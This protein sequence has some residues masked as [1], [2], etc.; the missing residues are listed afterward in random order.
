VTRTFPS[1]PTF[2][3]ERRDIPVSEVFLFFEE[4]LHGRSTGCIVAMQ[5]GRRGTMVERVDL[6]VRA[7]WLYP[8]DGKTE[9]VRDGEVA[10]RDGR[11]VHAGP[12]RREHWE[13]SDLVDAPG[14]A[15]L[16]G[17]VNCHCH[18]ASTFFRAQTED[19][20]GGRALYTVAFRGEGVVDPMDWARLAVLGT[21]EMAR[22]GI[23]TLNDFWYAPD[24]MGEAA[25]ATGLRMQLATEIVD[26]DKTRIADLDYT[27]HPALGART[28]RAGIEAAHRWHGKADGLIT[29]RI[30]PHAIDTV[31]EGLFRECAAEARAQGWGL[32]THAAQSPQECA[33]IRE[34]HGYGPAAWLAELGLLDRDWVLAHL[35]F[36]DGADLD[37]VAATGA[38]YAHA[39]SI[40]PRRGAF[41]DLTGIRA[42]GIRAGLA[43][44]WLQNDPF[45][46]MR[47]MLGATRIQAGSHTALSS[48]EALEMATA[49]AAGVL[50]LEDR[51]GR[52][53]PGREADMILVDLDR[54][55]LQPFYGTAASLVWHARADDVVRSWVRGRTVLCDGAV[56]GIDEGAAL[57]AVRARTP[58]FG[59]QLRE[60]GGTARTPTCPCG[61]H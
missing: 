42:R 56:R 12:A 30:G 21:A 35:T 57:A 53:T 13:A 50:G 2:R 43:T 38:G 22:A 31:S 40:Y 27:R 28:L 46:G 23:T 20:E 8:V 33:V 4:R 16:P 41:P 37:A 11:I 1:A 58:H 14:C 9:S 49:G 7:G 29:A 19:G 34:K 54:A 26:I 10:V 17:F 5:A 60:L 25:L 39:A 47:V 55:H 44:D 15:L 18:A 6:L 61:A 59:D 3:V 52:L 48:L 51:I 36:A 32:H 45:E 24:A